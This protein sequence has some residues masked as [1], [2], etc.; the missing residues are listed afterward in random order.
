M[1]KLRNILPS[2]LVFIF[3]VI[4]HLPDL[5]HDNFNTDVW[6][7]KSRSYAFGQAV[8]T[9][10][11]QDAIQKYHPGVTLMW[12]GF[13]GVKIH[14]FYLYVF[15]SRE[16]MDSIVDI[17]ALHFFQKLSVVIVV[18]ITLAFSY[19]V[20]EK[21]FGRRYALISV[22]LMTIEPFYMA[23]TR[24]FHLEGLMTTF[25]IASVL[26]FYYYLNISKKNLS[27]I[28]SAVFASLAFL[29]KTSSIF[30]F[31]F[32]GLVT[33]LYFSNNFK[34]FKKGVLPTARVV[35]I[36]LSISL[37]GFA[38][39][40]PA[41][42]VAPGRVFEYLYS[43]VSEVGVEQDH[44]Q[45]YFGKLVSDPGISF[46]FVVLALRSSIYLLPSL[47]GYFFV[48][49]RF[50]ADEKKFILYVFLFSFFYLIQLTI[51]SKK[52]DRY[53]LPAL[54]GFDLIVAFVI[55]HLFN[56]RCVFRK[57]DIQLKMFLLFLPGVLL[58]ISYHP[59]YLGY[60]SPYT[61]GMKVGIGVLEPKWMFGQSEIQSYFLDLK[62]AQGI[63]DAPDDDP[64]ERL[65]EN[66]KYKE[67]LSVA[68]PE[69]YYT[70]VWPFFRE[71]KTW[72]VIERLTPFAI[73]T[74]YYVF[75]VWDDYSNL[76]DRFELKYFD[77]I[78]VNG[79][80]SYRVYRNETFYRVLFEE[81]LIK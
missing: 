16:F 50:S 68:F 57:W 5:G 30:L 70:Q 9:G 32:V 48:R 65:I 4:V 42:W 78:Y 61:G 14:N 21:L 44:Q 58:L 81:G 74:K 17:F 54:L 43:G 3:F 19:Y 39:L 71:M 31:P 25:M 72:A 34:S 69:K 6:R 56:I 29:T 53:I 45:F 37:L 51:P 60:Y 40:W 27:L 63:V 64:Y 62:N 22:I 10:N 59:D 73:K 28:V 75:P 36:W 77:S 67:V 52:L 55:N 79:V 35:S 23:L 1:K 11:F 13:I 80:E 15:E 46:Y 2:I 7:W 41:M 38:L 24:V 33:F 12:L 47:I 49:G 8:A 20:L 18:G 66:K 76:E 26:W